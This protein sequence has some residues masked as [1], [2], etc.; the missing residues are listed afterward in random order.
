MRNHKVKTTGQHLKKTL[1]MPSRII[2]SLYIVDSF[3]GPQLRNVPIRYDI[4]VLVFK[5][6]NVKQEDLT[7]MDSK[8]SYYTQEA[9]LFC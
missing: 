6:Q 8:S 4:V 2:T 5:E 1:K 3:N 7:Q 9:T